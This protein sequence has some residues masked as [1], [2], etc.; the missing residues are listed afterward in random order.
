MEWGKKA[1]LMKIITEMNAEPITREDIVIDIINTKNYLI[2]CMENSPKY[3]DLKTKVACSDFS[4]L[5]EVE[6]ALA[7]AK[8][9]VKYFVNLLE[10][11]L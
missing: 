11:L 1:E 6:L 7:D 5:I 10:N 9:S 4:D 2:A 8:K 3:D